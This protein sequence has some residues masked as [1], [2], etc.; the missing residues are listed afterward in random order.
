VNAGGGEKEGEREKNGENW[1]ELCFIALGGGGRTP[2]HLNDVFCFKVVLFGSAILATV[3]FGGHLPQR[4]GV[5][6]KSLP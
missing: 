4:V 2:L 3:T 1:E 5:V 6:G